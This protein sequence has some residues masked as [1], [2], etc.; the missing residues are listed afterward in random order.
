MLRRR[1]GELFERLQTLDNP[2][3]AGKALMANLKGL[4]IYRVG[5][6]RVIARIKDVELLI[7]VVKIG[8]RKDVYGD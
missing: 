1:V 6:V 3:D 5:N 2:R 7:L 4:W 8:L